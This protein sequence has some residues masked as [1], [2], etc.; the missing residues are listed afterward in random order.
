MDFW[1]LTEKG[2]RSVFE[3]ERKHLDDEG[4]IIKFLNRVGSA[5]VETMVVATG[6]H[7]HGVNAILKRL[8]ERA[9][10]WKKSTRFAKF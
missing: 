6:I 4:K 1:M 7:E 5:P 9:W 3:I 10:V 8:S 2:K